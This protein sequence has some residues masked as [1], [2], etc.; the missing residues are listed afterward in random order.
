MTIP[1]EFVRLCK[2]NALNLSPVQLGSLEYYVNNLLSWN[3]RVNLI[4]RKDESNIW[5]S[6]ILHSL[7][8]VE[9]VELPPGSRLLDLGS[10]GGLPG[11]PIAILRPDLQVTLLDSV[12]KKTE[13]VRDIV[14]GLSM[15][16][17]TVTWGRAGEIR[18]KD[19]SSE[20]FD[21][22]IARAVAPL[23]DLIRWSLTLVRRTDATTSR[24]EPKTPP[25][26]FSTP[27]LIA[28][29]GGSLE[30]ELRSA[31]VRYGNKRISTLDLVVKGVSDIEL[32][33]KKLVAV[34][35]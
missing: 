19:A 34:E 26:H 15:G 25:A 17:L 24:K 35:L 28:M 14:S 12:R 1:I 3:Q 29:K 4:S 11:V 10:G 27:F 9:R 6:H 13:A 8:L 5:V 7:C 33:E 30:H 16:N 20:G 32:V 21:V 31:Q 2:L 18:L 23:K 22:V